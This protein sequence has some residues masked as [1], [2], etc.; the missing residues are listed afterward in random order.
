ME[1]LPEL[2]VP[3]AQQWLS[4]SPGRI[5]PEGY[6]WMQAVHWVAGSGLYQPRRHRSSGLR[7]FSTT[8]VRVAQ[9][10]TDLT[11]CFPGIDYLMRRTGL[12]ERTVEYHLAALRETGLLAYITRGTRVRGERAQASEFARM[13]PVEFDQALG[14][15]TVGEGVQRRVTGIAESG[16]ELM[17]R[18]GK[19]AR[20]KVRTRRSKTSRKTVS[21]A[22]TGPILGRARCTPMGGGAE[23]SSAAGVTPC[24]PESKLASGASKSSTPESSPKTAGGRRKLNKVARRFQLARELT[25][26]LDW[27]RGCAVPRI[28]WVT[29]HV[30]DAGWTVTDVRGWLHLRGEAARVRR[31]SGLLAVLLDG[32]ENTLNTPAKRTEAVEKWRSAQEAARRERIQQ[33][34]A[35]AERFEGDWQ[36]PASRAVQR[37]VEAAFA[38][39]REVAT[40]R[41]QDQPL[42]TD[43]QGDDAAL[44]DQQV[45]NMRIRARDELLQGVTDLIDLAV[46]SMGR[47]AAA[48]L[49]GVD[50]VRRAE[51]LACGARSSLMTYGNQ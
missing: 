23:G 34:R 39:V 27:L 15:R 35:R 37:E 26:E 44:T 43:H 14:I 32:A 41:C 28:A 13:I 36:A 48:H 24:P 10:L 30:A 11:P 3:P 5:A 18:L 38:Q 49:Y 6:S 19:K 51:Q 9:L 1:V 33:V 22:S 21:G 8:T 42:S 29:R 45:K 50:L 7:S 40:G 25:E 20:K 46:D 2:W 16:R 4:S 31:G 47:E 12:S 17:A